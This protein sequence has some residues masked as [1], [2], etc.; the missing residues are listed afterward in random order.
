MMYDKN[1]DAAHNGIERNCERRRL[2]ADVVGGRF[3]FGGTRRSRFQR[4]WRS[5]QPNRVPKRRYAKK[6]DLLL[7]LDASAEEAQLR[8]AEAEAELGRQDLERSRGLASQKVV[9]K[10]EL[11]AAES[12]FNRLNAVADQMRSN[13]REE[14][15]DRAIRWPARDSP[16]E[17]RAN[18]QLRANKWCSFTS[19]DSVFAD[20]AL[21]QH[22]LVS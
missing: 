22:I 21:P 13:I 4:A 16:G 19:L 8:S 20:F 18:D 3:H 15:D 7:Q 14:D 12:K 5:C 17:H 9:S 2:G 1:G 10:A 11:D 6:G